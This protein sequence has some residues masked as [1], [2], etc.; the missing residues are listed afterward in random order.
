LAKIGEK[1]YKFGKKTCKFDLYGH[2]T[3]IRS[4]YVP[5]KG[6][7]H[8]QVWYLRMYDVCTPISCEERRY[9]AT[10]GRRQ[11]K[12]GMDLNTKIFSF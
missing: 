3:L 6:S 4:A 1:F 9:V 12:Q 11:P 8:M 10:H 7:I 2:T 5:C